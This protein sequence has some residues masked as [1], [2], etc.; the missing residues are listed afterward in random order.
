MQNYEIILDTLHKSY[1]DKECFTQ[2]REP[3]LF[4]IIL[5]T[6]QI[7]NSIFVTVSKLN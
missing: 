4:Y 2:I 3:K 7:I 6:Q 5:N 1:S